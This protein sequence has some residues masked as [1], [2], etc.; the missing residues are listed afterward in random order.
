MEEEEFRPLFIDL[1]GYGNK[2]IEAMYHDIK[3]N[4][5][6]NPNDYFEEAG[7]TYE[8]M[9]SALCGPL[10]IQDDNE[11]SDG[12]NDLICKINSI[13]EHKHSSNFR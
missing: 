4:E 5:S 10:Y 9:K 13:I 7:I 11:F 6:T 1:F 2:L 12:M 8:E 3:S